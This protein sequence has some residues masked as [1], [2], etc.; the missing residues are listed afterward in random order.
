MFTAVADV[1]MGYLV[2]HRDLQRRSDIRAA[3]R[4]SC[5]LYL[6]GM[7]LNDVFDAEVDAREQPERPIPSGRV[8]LQAATIV[9][10]GMLTAG[11]VVAWCSA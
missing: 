10:W 7:V 2:T 3:G 11:I 1:T 6:S 5:L 4:A 9:G 8:S